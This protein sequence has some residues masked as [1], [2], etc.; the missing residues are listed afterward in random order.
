MA[1]SHF[2]AGIAAVALVLMAHLAPAQPPAQALRQVAEQKAESDANTALAAAD[3]L[4]RTAPAE[5]AGVLRRAILTL[6]KSVEIGSEKRAAL[7]RKLDAR[8]APLEGRAVAPVQVGVKPA[9]DPKVAEAARAEAKDVHDTVVELEKLYRLDKFAEAQAKITALS[10]K[11]PDNPAVLVLAGQGAIADRVGE[12]QRMAKEQ[13]D[14]A[15][16]ALRDVDRSAFPA[17]G[18]IEF[19]AGFKEKMERRDRLSGVTLGAEEEAILK[20]LETKVA[21]GVK[22]GPF[23]EVIES[24]ATLIQKPIIVDKAGMSENA[25]DAKKPVTMPGDVSARTAL[26][27]VVQAQGMTFIIKDKFIQ[28]V[29]LE[30]AR[31]TL[32][33]RAYYMGDVLSDPQGGGAT[34]GP[35][36]DYAAAQKN[37]ALI[38]DS[39]KASI[40]PQVWEG[41]GGIATILFHAPS[42]SIVVSAPAEVHF[43]IGNAIRGRR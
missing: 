9:A 29:T 25:L 4:A 24:L 10:R 12:S 13:A 26:R 3:K 31:K 43:N 6:D 37:A 39:I 23:E 35:F 11:Y 1:R 38:V 42:M 28:V 17:K 15:L 21:Q 8:L 32:V 22:D 40:D 16:F 33:K 41:K 18:D 2:R 5:A 14:R 36:A 27:A 19:P 30:Q 20:A 34:V 7:V